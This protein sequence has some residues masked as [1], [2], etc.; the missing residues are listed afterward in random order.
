MTF[1]TFSSAA[2]P[3]TL[4]VACT[5]MPVRHG[6]P[7]AISQS[8]RVD[9][10]QPGKFSDVGDRHFNDDRIR[11]AYLEL[12]RKHIVRSAT[13]HLADGQT[14]TISISEV[15]MAGAFEF[16]RRGSGDFRVIRDIYPPRID[17]R[18]SLRG[19]DGTQVSSGERRLRDV[20][21][22]MH[23][24]LTRNDLLRYEKA[25]IDR[26]LESEWPGRKN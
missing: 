14:L 2:L 3:C 24:N 5:A 25:L 17:L 22:L 10:D 15:D 18:F 23:V 1:R 20:A 19:A 13:S 4:L 26:W 12:L 11:A 9:Y 8:V 16:S 7:P 6:E 21:Y